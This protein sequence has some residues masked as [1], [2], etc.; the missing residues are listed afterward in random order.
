MQRDDLPVLKEI[1]GKPVDPIEVRLALTL[2]GSRFVY[3][4]ISI[5]IL[6]SFHDFF[7]TGCRITPYSR[8]DRDVC[9]PSAPGHSLKSR[10]RCPYR[11]VFVCVYLK[12]FICL[13][14]FEP[15]CRIYLWVFHKWMDFTLCATLMTSNSWRI[16]F[17]IFLWICAPAMCSARHPLTRNNLLCA[18]PSSRWEKVTMNWVEDYRGL[19]WSL[20]YLTLNV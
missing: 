15:L 12:M 11:N 5:K 9:L 18:H 13:E 1:L 7:I 17:N 2:S 3:F 8:T 6:H 4:Y 19:I 16:W 14:H 10:C 20:K